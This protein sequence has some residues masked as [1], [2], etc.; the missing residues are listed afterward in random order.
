[1][2]LLRPIALTLMLLASAASLADDPC[3]GFSWN[4]TH[5]RAVFSSTALNAKAGADAA[6][7]P[8]I[9][10]N[11]LYDLTLAPQS[12]VHFQVPPGKPSKVDSP[13]AG[14]LHLKLK[15]QGLYRISADQPFWIDVVGGE[16]LIRSESFQGAAGCNA[17]HKI[18]Q[19]TLP[20]GQ[21]LTVQVSGAGS[22]HARIAV[23][24]APIS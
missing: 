22:A 15:T 21:E 20:A 11:H 9:T 13:Y 24:P 17:P 19:F 7:A 8:A 6:S 12:Q 1:M 2:T 5:E 23:T 16:E 14:L 4:V 3:S 18:V 10:A